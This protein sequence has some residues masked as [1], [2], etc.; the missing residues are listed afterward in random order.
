VGGRFGVSWTEGN[1][2]AQVSEVGLWDGVGK[3]LLDYRYEVVQGANRSEGHGV[4]AASGAAEGGQE[5]GGFDDRQRDLTL[6]K[7][8]QQ[9]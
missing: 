2:T 4:G 6:P 7:L 8:M 3:Q 5:E 1:F 9:A